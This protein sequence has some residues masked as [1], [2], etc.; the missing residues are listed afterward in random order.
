M[1]LKDIVGTLE[2][3]IICGD[4]DTEIKDITNNS[5][6]KLMANLFG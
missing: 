1:L 4:L 6:C 5:K 3:E 2:I